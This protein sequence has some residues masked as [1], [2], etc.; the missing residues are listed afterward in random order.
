MEFGHLQKARRGL[1]KTLWVLFRQMYVIIES[2]SSFYLYFS[3]I[4][5]SKWLCWNKRFIKSPGPSSQ[6]WMPFSCHWLQQANLLMTVPRWIMLEIRL[7]KAT[8]DRHWVLLQTKVC[9]SFDFFHTSA[10]SLFKSSNW[11]IILHIPSI[12][13]PHCPK[14]STTIEWLIFPITFFNIS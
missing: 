14:K 1:L 3:L 5:L 2:S 10:N 12:S 9:M 11:N 8:L 7:M 4:L 6:S 13:S